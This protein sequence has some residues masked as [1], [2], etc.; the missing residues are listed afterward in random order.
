MIG[1]VSECACISYVA[2]ALLPSQSRVPRCGSCP[3]LFP[4]PR[5]EAWRLPFSLLASGACGDD[6]SPGLHRQSLVVRF[7]LML[8]CGSASP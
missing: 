6:A 4:E 5:A 7:M 3:A 1:D 2:A 8:L